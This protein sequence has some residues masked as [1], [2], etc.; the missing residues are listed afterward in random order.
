MQWFHAAEKEPMLK[1]YYMLLR[2][3][4]SPGCMHHIVSHC[5][6]M[7]AEMFKVT[8]VSACWLDRSH[9]FHILHGLTIGFAS[10]GAGQLC[11]HPRNPGLLSRPNWTQPADPTSRLPSLPFFSR[12]RLLIYVVKR[13]AGSSKNR[14][15]YM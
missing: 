10:V 7:S 4:P 13:A 3:Q 9:K 6:Q 1:L 5:R 12:Q 15:P 2:R 8:S 11:S 14:I